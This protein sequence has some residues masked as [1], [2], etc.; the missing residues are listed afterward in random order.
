MSTQALSGDGVLRAAFDPITSSLKTSGLVSS[1]LAPSG[2]TSLVY[3][4]ANVAGGSTT[5][6]LT[7]LVPA[8]GIYIQ[9]VYL[10]GTSIG[11]YRLYKNGVPMAV[12]RMSQTEYSAII[13]LAT[14][15]SWGLSTEIGDLISVEVTNASI[16]PA[17]FDITIQN[18]NS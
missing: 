1:K 18:L 17:T 16:N 13:F 9:T 14:A 6:V 11:E 10:S 4:N 8:D 3:S 15:T 12:Y 2:E 5:S 7:Y